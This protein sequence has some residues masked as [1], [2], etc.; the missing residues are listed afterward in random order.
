MRGALTG[1]V[2]VTILLVVG[3]LVA[4]NAPVAAGKATD[5]A[6]SADTTKKLGLDK[7][8]LPP[9][10]VVIVVDN[11][12]EGVALQ[13]N[14]VLMSPEEYKKLLDTKEQLDKL[15][16][17]DKKTAHACKLTGRLEGDF[18]LV[19]AVFAFT[20][21]QPRTTVVL[22][23]QGAHLMDEGDLDGKLP[24]LDIGEEGFLL[25]VDKEG[26]H[27]LTLNLKAAVSF[28]RPTTPSGS[29]ERG[30]DLGLPGAA[31]TT[32]ALDLPAG[33]KEIR[34]NDILEKPA[35]P[36]HWELA[37]G[38]IKSLSV[39]W[40]EPVS[41]PGNAPLLHADS[42][43]TV[44][45][46]ENQVLVSAD[47][48]L[49]DQRGQTKEWQLLLPA[50]A[51][52]DLKTPSGLAGDVVYP[53][54][55]RPT[56]LLR[57]TEPTAERVLVNVQ[58][59]YPRPF[60]GPRLPIGP[61]FVYGTN[62]QEATITVQA[63]PDAL[64]GQ[65]LVYHRFGDIYPRDIQA[66][67][68]GPTA[69]FHVWNVPG[70]ARVPKAPSAKAPLELE[71]KMDKGVADATVEHLLRLKPGGRTWLVDV[72]TTIRMKGKPDLLDIQLPRARIPRIGILGVATGVGFPASLSWLPLA[73]P[74]GK[75]IPQAVPLDFA[76]DDDG[77]K[78]AQPDGQRRTR[79]TWNRPP[80]DEIKLTGKYLV[81]F[82]ADRLHIELPRPVEILDRGGKVTVEVGE[83]LELLAG[84][85]GSEGP[86][87]DKHKVQVIWDSFPESVDIAWKPYRPE[88]AVTGLTDVT[89]HDRSAEIKAQLTF[90]VPEPTRASSAPPGQLQF[91]VPAAI[92]ELKVEAG[93][94]LIQ[95][96]PAR[97]SAWVLVTA[98]PGTRAEVLLRYDVTLPRKDVQGLKPRLAQIPL[99]WP[100]GATREDA[101][102]RIWSDT[103]TRPVLFEAPIGEEVWRDHGIEIVP[104][105]DVVPALVLHGVGLNLPLSL[106]LVEPSATKL[107][108]MVCDRGLIQVTVDEEGTHT[109]RARYWVR[110][111]NARH[112]DVELPMPAA[113][114]LHN[115]WLDQLKVTNWEPL[116]PV[117]NIAQIPINPRRFNQ[118]MV[119]EIEYKLPASFT[120]SKRFW[121]TLYAPQFRGDA[122]LGLIRWQVGLPFSWVALVPGGRMDY[123]WGIQGWLLGPEPSVTSTELEAW[124]TGKDS[125]ETPS[126]VNLAF[127]RTGQD[128]VQLLH[129]SRQLWLLVCSG[130][131]LG[132][133]LGLYV[134]PL[135]RPVFWLV[136]SALGV[137]AMAVGIM[138]PGWV[139]AFV[140]GCQPGVLVLVVLLGIQWMLQESY[141]RQLV[142]MP[143]FTRVKANSSLLRTG[144]PRREP[145]TVDAPALEV[146]GGSSSSSKSQGS[147]KG[148]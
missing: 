80:S 92:K 99:V 127:T 73:P 111:F 44:K 54:A 96:D 136:S 10:G 77:A 30:F 1:C 148:N 75:N 97:D 71:I 101:K 64:R 70:V 122:F 94:K 51:R 118:P 109:Y 18:I 95:H 50:N 117:P 105:V 17:F 83:Q 86:A 16:K 130:L 11:P 12:K 28:K 48:A 145:S 126:A 113:N 107:A 47:M 36:N 57:L 78:L 42:T 128:T 72:S 63:S 81:P 9:G 121:T 45:L 66:K 3:P 65:R 34:W 39:A 2:G 144:G 82:G 142:F 49:E 133:G 123:R 100:E 114:C 41:V 26:T 13:P 58:V 62:R 131:V 56:Y 7:I 88:F 146:N 31:V 147:K 67:G 55:G 68:P 84:V 87:L 91:R 27:Q 74:S 79:L 6:K 25:R 21:E 141:R 69:V 33:V 129:V 19:R 102:V 124:L 93:G 23:L 85:A 52:V 140:F 125:R 15:I 40:K 35:A 98:E 22:G 8:K 60:A 53:D 89:L 14:L 29:G 5:P 106:R 104:E 108:S 38:K 110:K 24:L 37:L 90:L 137:G 112:L 61:F 116:E 32:L 120:D 135:S 134:L 76:C 4:Q 119:L 59:R 115:V 103:A 138:W 143:G 46:D 43:I 139:P 132:V 20:T